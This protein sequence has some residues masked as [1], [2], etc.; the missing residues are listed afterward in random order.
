MKRK[1]DLPRKEII[2]VEKKDGPSSSTVLEKLSLTRNKKGQLVGE[3]DG[4]KNLFE[5]GKGWLSRRTKNW[6][7]RSTSLKSS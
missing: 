7:Q 1:T 3:F 6:C 2:N 5:K 4:K